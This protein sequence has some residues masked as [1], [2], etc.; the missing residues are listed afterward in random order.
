MGC[1]ALQG[2]VSA[3]FNIAIGPQAGQLIGAGGCNVFI[4]YGAATSSGTATDNDA[5]QNVAIGMYAAS[6]LTDGDMNTLVGHYASAL[7]TT[8]NGNV[9]LGAFAGCSITTSGYNVFV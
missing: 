7:I 6:A 5:S 4:G 8:G 2:N 3:D 9:S 1:K